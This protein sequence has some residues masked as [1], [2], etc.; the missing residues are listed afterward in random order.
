MNHLA[1]SKVCQ[2]KS[3][4]HQERF[5]DFALFFCGR[6]SELHL[7]K[8]APLAVYV[9]GHRASVVGGE[10][11]GVPSSPVHAVLVPV[12]VFGM[13]GLQHLDNTDIAHVGLVEGLFGDDDVAV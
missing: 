4:F 5:I 11:C 2:L 10:R 8:L 6:R 13:V 9:L 3:R 12:N 7:F 1:M